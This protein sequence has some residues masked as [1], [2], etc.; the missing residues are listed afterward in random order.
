[1]IPG[2]LTVLEFSLTVPRSDPPEL[3]D[4]NDERGLCLTIG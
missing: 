1:M 4:E 2:R 3:A